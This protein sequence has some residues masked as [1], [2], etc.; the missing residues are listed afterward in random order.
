MDY[1]TR[2]S[3]EVKYLA[4]H[5]IGADADSHPYDV[6]VYHIEH[7][8]WPG[9]GYHYQILKDGTIFQ[10]N[11]LQTMCYNVAGRNHEVIGILINGK[12]LPFGEN[13]PTKAQIK[14][15]NQLI[16]Y[17]SSLLPNKVEVVGHKDI[18]L[19]SSPTTCPGNLM[20]YLEE[21]EQV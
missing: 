18:A 19:P 17:L 21:G 1:R 3:R 16:K 2:D 7:N 11:Y 14:S 20:E 12:F 6:A 5:H 4:F 9:H 13:T 8:D 15:A 10:T